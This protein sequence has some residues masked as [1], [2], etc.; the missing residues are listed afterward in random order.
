MIWMLNF[1]LNTENRSWVRGNYFIINF[2]SIEGVV[3]GNFPSLYTFP[4]PDTEIEFGNI[5]NRNK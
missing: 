4:L 3:D 1:M 2:A 5:V